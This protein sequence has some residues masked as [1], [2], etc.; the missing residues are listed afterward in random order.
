MTRTAFVLL[1]LLACLPALAQEP[2]PSPPAA[3]ALDPD[4]S[5]AAAGEAPAPGRV[6]SER[7]GVLTPITVAA[8]ET[9]QG[10]VV[11]VGGN[12][13]VAGRVLGDIVVVGGT[14]E[15]SGAVDGQVVAVG[16]TV[17]FGPDASVGEDVVTVGSVVDDAGLEYG[18]QRVN[19][20]PV[21]GIPTARG[22]FGVFSAIL[23]WM[24][25]LRVFLVFVVILAYLALAPRQVLELSERVRS[26]YVRALLIGLVAHVA[27][28]V[29][30]LLLAITV[31]GLPVLLVLMAGFWM[32]R[33]L[34]RA[35]LFHAVGH[36]LGRGISGEMSLVGATLL[37]FVPWALLVVLPL[38]F[39]FAGLILALAV[40]MVLKLLVD[41]PAIGGVLEWL[42]EQR[43]ARG[44]AAVPP[45]P[46]AP[47]V[48]PLTA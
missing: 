42:F 8:D 17:T 29:L 1:L 47:P 23:G 40:R 30:S 9:V 38:F 3:P 39:G 48:V 32:L 26:G 18:G 7:V 10:D 22:A 11:C 12:A 16:S 35:G 15:L 45:P 21:F 44:S 14:L 20:I 37:G 36:G 28:L 31:I 24:A 33:I 5:A 34:G 27:M 6:V 19:V 2:A 46:P 13:S 4:A 43:R 25:L 41:C